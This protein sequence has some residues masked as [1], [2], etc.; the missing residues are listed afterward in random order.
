MQ[1]CPVGLLARGAC[2][3]GE[4]TWPSPAAPP[5]PLGPAAKRAAR[6]LLLLPLALNTSPRRPRRRNPKMRSS[7]NDP[8][9]SRSALPHARARRWPFL[10]QRAQCAWKRVRN[11]AHATFLKKNTKKVVPEGDT[12]PNRCEQLRRRHAPQRGQSERPPPE[13]RRR[14]PLSR[15]RVVPAAA[16]RR[17]RRRPRCRR[18]T[19]T[20]ALAPCSRRGRV[21]K[22]EARETA[23][24][25]KR[26]QGPNSPL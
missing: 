7:F 3:T 17:R 19:R 21:N 23:G 25:F 6:P 13:Q 14:L 1:F 24:R 12:A 5:P 10:N 8:S 11:A 2:G 15:R 16:C 20:A 18:P 26:P 22:V 4:V 9:S